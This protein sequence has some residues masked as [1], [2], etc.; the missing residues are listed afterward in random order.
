MIDTRKTEKRATAKDLAMATALQRL[1]REVQDQAQGDM[2]LPSDPAARL[3]ALNM[4]N[5]VFDRLDAAIERHI[6]SLTSK[7][8]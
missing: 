6:K 8:S 1:C 5:N 2:T 3:I 7:S 4:M